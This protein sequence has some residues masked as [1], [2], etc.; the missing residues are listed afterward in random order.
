[1][2]NENHKVMAAE[3]NPFVIMGKIPSE[4][5]CDREDETQRIVK[6]IIGRS[7]DMLIM[8]ERRMGKTSLINHCFDC[9]ELKDNFYTFYFDI[10]H[11][12]SFQ[13]FVY[14]FQREVFKA[15]MPKGQKVITSLLTALKS[16]T[17][18]FSI[19]PISGMPTVSLELGSI[20]RPEYT[21]SEILDFLENAD[22]P[23]IIAID[24]FQRVA[25]Y[26]DNVE[27][28][29][30][31]KIQHLKNT[32]FIFAGS[33]RH[34]LS[35]M[36]S[37]YSRP[38]YNSTITVSLDKIDA[39]IYA[40]FAVNIFSK[41][42]KSIEKDVFLNLY[43]Y[44]DGNTFC[45]HKMLHIAF[46]KINENECCTK[47]ILNQV[48]NEIVEDNEHYY[49]ES[50]SRMS[51]KQKLV[52][53]AIAIDGIAKQVTSTD[54]IKRHSL[55]SASSVQAAIRVL[56]END[57]INVKEKEYFISDKFMG[58]WLKRMAGVITLI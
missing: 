27:A 19:D 47:E 1:M 32:R 41:F 25:L 10:L 8:S 53:Y 18:Q 58:I 2:L 23:C 50:L 26:S 34:L 6:E 39:E 13:E 21:F 46:D 7:A 15:L 3:M 12:S 35:E 11:T 55:G 48:L 37:S 33:E 30:R 4:Y 54:F 16:I 45:I 57:W 49:R 17:P 38:F 42:S 51:A 14:E 20:N 31:G 9:P 24:E 52:F 29:L 44:F 22:K 43:D 56:M 36:F 5:F 28:F 40:E